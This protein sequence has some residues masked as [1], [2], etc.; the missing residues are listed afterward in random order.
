MISYIISHLLSWMGQ[1]V[2][3]KLL[4]RSDKYQDD[5]DE[6]SLIYSVRPARSYAVIG[7]ISMVMG[8]VFVF[9]LFWGDTFEDKLD[10]TLIGLVCI[11][12][13]IFL[14]AY[15]YKY[16]F[17]YDGNGFVSKSFIKNKHYYYDDISG[18][19]FHGQGLTIAM[20]NRKRFCICNEYAGSKRMQDYILSIIDKNKVYESYCAYKY[21]EDENVS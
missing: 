2:T 16:N 10:G 20:K 11:I 5:V 17:T 12:L 8:V 3:L 9:A 18:V 13:G 14:T 1:I 21:R 7:F 4:K 15:Y 6:L 19:Y